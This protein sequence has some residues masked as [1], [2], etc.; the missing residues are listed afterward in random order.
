M[1]STWRPLASLLLS[2]SL[3]LGA[4]TTTPH[5]KALKH[6][7]LGDAA[8]ARQDV[9]TAVLEYRIAAISDPTFGEAHLKLAE[10]D[11]KNDNLKAAF[12]EYVRAAD[13]LPDRADVQIKAGNLLLLAGRFLD[14][15]TRARAVLMKDPKNTAAMVLLG[16]SLAGLKDLDDALEVG[17]KAADL[18]PT[19][20]GE[21]RNLGVL[22][23]AKGNQALA[24]EEFKKATRLDPNSIS[25]CLALAQFYRSTNRNTDAEPWLKRAVQINPKDLR[26]NQQ[27]GSFYMETGRA[28]LAEPYLQMVADEAKDVDS[29]LGLADYYLAAGRIADARQLL[30]KLAANPDSWA[31][32]TVRLAIIDSATGHL[33]A[34]IA[35]VNSVIAKQP[36]NVSA[37]TVKARLLVAEHR[38][39]EALKVAETAVAANPKSAD[40]KVMLGHIDLVMH[41]TEAARQAFNDAL[42]NDPNSTDAQIQLSGLAL[43]NGETQS[44]IDYA[45]RSVK[46][47]PDNLEARLALV[48]ALTAEPESRERAKIEVKQLMAHY[49]TSARV[50]DVA[51]GL[52]LTQQDLADAKKAWQRAL[53]LDDTDT[54][55]MSGLAGLLISSKNYTAAERLVEQHLGPAPAQTGALLVAAK[56]RLAANDSAKAEVFLKQFVAR[57]P[58]RLEG[59]ALLGQIY[60]AQKRIGE[61]EQEFSVLVQQEPQSSGAMTMLGLLAEA[62]H[63]ENSAMKW[64]DRAVQ[65]DAHAAVAANNLAW[66]YLNRNQ[67]LDIA[68]QLAE[69]ASGEQ[70]TESE[71]SDTLGVIYSRKQ[72]FSMAIRTLQRSVD[73]DPK[74]PIHLYHL[75]MAYADAGDDANARKTLQTAL[76]ISASF[77]GADQAR[78]VL[79]TLLY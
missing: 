53:E 79:A 62:S 56:V 63:D 23:L 32:A 4:C 44:S 15:R 42:T 43:A 72:L 50:F 52:A 66:I 3:V 36:K 5:A 19:S 49:P 48:R 13:L 30:G 47:E 60:M 58:S 2:S 28:A 61:A 73:Q 57:D 65:S 27:L 74:N 41:R 70:P 77:D 31:V 25:A 34:A 69:A 68:L 6:V 16:N 8:L 55:A 22:E 26:A 59:F 51:A 54:D 75:G 18:A 76:K 46:S 9:A 67:N 21:Y 11:V 35:G 14:A 33:D 38:N 64:Y 71:F 7:A 24:E 78:K 17:Q 1:T 12:P 29:Q 20:E 39:E 37:L 40:A 10:A 45:E